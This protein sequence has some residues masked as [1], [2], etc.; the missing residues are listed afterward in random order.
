MSLTQ[1]QENF[2]LK[3]VETGNASE[4]YRS[5]YRADKMKNTT[6]AVR[7]CELLSDSKVTVRVEEIKK[8]H[9]ER[10][11]LTVDDLLAELEEARQAALSAETVQASA[12][13]NATMGKA[14]LLGLDKQIIDHKSS[15]GSMTPSSIDKSLV[16]AL[17]D[18][19][20]D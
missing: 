17:A 6:I 19:L 2:C 10:H 1:K 8:D 11:K 4:A 14:K 3:Y 16:E 18:K 20:V 15:D 5:A 9:R 12:A 13:T 7:A